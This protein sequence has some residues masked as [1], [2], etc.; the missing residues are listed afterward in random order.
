[1]TRDGPDT[2]APDTDAPDTDTSAERHYRNW[3]V[4]APL[5]LLATGLGASG[6]GQS[7]L[8]KGRGAP[9]WKWVAA[10]TASLVALN[11]G[12]CLFGDAIKHRAL[13]EWAH[14]QEAEADDAGHAE[15]LQ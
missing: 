7:T 14:E 10:G 9:T 15:G 5:G 1:M 4:L 3:T 12:L 2:D 6:V 8:L 13:Y 11:A